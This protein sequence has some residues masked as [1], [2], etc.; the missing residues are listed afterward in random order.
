MQLKWSST[1]L[2]CLL[3]PVLSF[4][5]VH[6]V[7]TLSSGKAS[8]NIFSST[9]IHF[10]PYQNTYVGTNHFD[11]ENDTG[12]FIGVETSFLEK[13]AWQIGLSYFVNNAF[14]AK[15]NVYQFSDPA[16][17][18]LTYQYQIVSRRISVEG[19]LSHE[20]HNVWH[21]YI[22]AS[23]GMATNR[24]YG[25]TEYPV[26]DFDVPMSMPFGNHTNKTFTFSLGLGVDV[27]LSEHIRIGAG[28]R[29]VDL[30]SAALGTTPLETGNQTITNPDI[31]AN[32]LL[33]QVSFIG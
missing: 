31:H 6:P 26:T 21:P 7:V 5:N 9:I 15:G 24:A 30:G 19:K 22:L 3:C 16:Y 32:E 8:A 18:N 20:L 13:W 25:Y 12:L 29:F 11:S 23:L 14:T 17:N 4:A 27:N 10:T 1:C 2:I 28:Y 33:A